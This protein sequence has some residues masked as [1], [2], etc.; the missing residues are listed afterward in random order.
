MFNLEYNIIL[1]CQWIAKQIVILF[2]LTTYFTLDYLQF[3][4]D[5][6]IKNLLSPAN[7]F[8]A[9]NE[10]YSALSSGCSSAVFLGHLEKLF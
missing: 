9:L 2:F 4:I 3:D 8:E 6:V 7:K 10:L 1:K 5:S